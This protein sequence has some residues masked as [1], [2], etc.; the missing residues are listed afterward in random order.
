M[1]NIYPMFCG[2][3]DSQFELEM[4]VT[5]YSLGGHKCP[6]CCSDKV[7]SDFSVKRGVLV[8]DQTRWNKGNLK[9]RY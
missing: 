1:N 5:E 8:D 7:Q 3:C 6:K 4:K 2:D 9:D